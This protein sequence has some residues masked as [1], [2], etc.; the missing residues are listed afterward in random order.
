MRDKG[1]ARDEGRGTRDDGQGTRDEGR[2]T[3]LLLH[4]F[5]E[6]VERRAYEA[7]GGHFVAPAQRMTDFVKGKSSS[8]LPENSYLRG[9]VPVNMKE[10]LPDFVF[11]SLQGAFKA[12]GKKMK[13][14]F[15]E[16]AIIIAPE[17][18]TSSPVRIPRDPET[19]QHPQIKNLY[20]C[21]EGAGYAGGI[22]SAAM[23]G[24]RVANHLSIF[25]AAD[26]FSM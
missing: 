3:S 23:D 20:P 1:T 19:L 12:F 10:V 21:A 22:V 11:E 2:G 6:S 7:G 26:N 25:S 16:E 14:Y 17:S 24:Q 5:Q 4:H 18:R 13:G 15:T 8:T 9:V